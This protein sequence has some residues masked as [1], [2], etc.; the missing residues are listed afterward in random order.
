MTPALPT[1]DIPDL[2]RMTAAEFATAYNRGEVSPHVMARMG[3]EPWL[4]L[5]AHSDGQTVIDVSQKIEAIVSEW[6]AA[7]VDPMNYI[8]RE[9]Q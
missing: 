1:F 8:G 3:L 6:T 4:E 5:V 2:G 9:E 7:T